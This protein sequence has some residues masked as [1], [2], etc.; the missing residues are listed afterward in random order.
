MPVNLVF[1]KDTIF[2]KDFSNA[3][4]KVLQAVQIRK[5][6]KKVD[7]RQ[8]IQ[9]QNAPKCQGTEYIPDIITALEEQRILEF[10]Y[11]KFSDDTDKKRTLRPYLLKEDNNRWYIIGKPIG[12]E[13]LKTFAI[14]RI[15]SL[16]IAEEYF[17]PDEVDFKEHYNYSFG[18]I[19]SEEPP[20]EVILSFE[21]H[22]GN[23]IKTLPLHHTQKIIADD[24]NQLT[25]SVLVKPSYEFYSKILSF[26]KDVKV[27]SP[28]HVQEKI[29]EE[30][31]TLLKKYQ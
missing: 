13:T 5:S 1:I 16:S 20:V 25:V 12:K 26:G 4:E 17:T 18:V 24:S 28:N 3:I 27:V 15:T 21:P 9:T 6:I 31:S 22:Q 29:K 2:Y 7:Q 23:Y 8:Y 11:Q 19:V 10:G 30:V 14:D